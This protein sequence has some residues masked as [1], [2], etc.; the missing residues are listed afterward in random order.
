MEN[1][2]VTIIIPNWNGRG[3]LPDC[4]ESL[5]KIDWLNY[6]VVVVD[7][8]STDGSIAFIRQN[9]PD[10][11]LIE[12]QKNLGFAAACNQG[13]KWAFEHSADFILLL[14]NDTV[15]GPD[16]LT[17]MMGVFRELRIGI[18]GAKIYYYNQPNKIWFAGGKFVWWRASGKNF[19]WQK[20]DRPELTGIRLCDFVT[21]C[22]M[23][24]KKEIFGD[25]GYFYEPYFLNVEDLDFCW[26]AKKAGWKI[27]VNLDAK[28]WH[29]VG[30]SHFGEFSFINNYYGVRNRLYFAFKRSSNFLGGL[31]LL[32]FVVPARIIQGTLMGRFAM[33]RG[34]IFGCLDFFRGKMGRNDS[35]VK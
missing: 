34:M 13:I 23:L 33:I 17:R 32:L 24:I 9:H 21:G 10:T 6:E 4:L 8:G 29:K 14:N 7:N 30:A 26:R 5:S 22:A 1:Q 28:I 19:Y 16:F 35:L 11:I 27:V 12:N 18:V 31:V 15:V 3:F 2:K 25:I 20:M